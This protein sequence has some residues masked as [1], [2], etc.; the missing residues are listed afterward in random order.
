MAKRAV[1]LMDL[2]PTILSLFGLP[3][4]GRFMGQSLVPFMRG[5]TPVLA[6]PLAV[7]NGGNMRAMLFDERFKAISRSGIDEVYDLRDDPGETKNL[8]EHPESRVRLATLRAF[9]DGLVPKAK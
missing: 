3:T 6:R 5:E 9:F 2:G 1:S 7:D 8:A 4:P